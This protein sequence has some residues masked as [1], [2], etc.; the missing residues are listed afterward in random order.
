MVKVLKLPLVQVN[1]LP[2]QLLSL[3]IYL[4]MTRKY[5]N[6]YI[7]LIMLL[8]IGCN[9]KTEYCFD[10]QSE[11]Y[12]LRLKFEGKL[13]NKYN[14]KKNRGFTTLVIKTKNGVIK[15][16]Q[17][18]TNDY[19]LYKDVEQGDSLFKIKGSL[20]IKVKNNKGVK[21]YKDHCVNFRFRLVGDSL[22]KI[23]D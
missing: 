11:K 8:V 10:I 18:L 1:Q 6:Y 20:D 19:Q 12:L 16:Y 21:V 2:L 15:Y 3:L 9:N 13:L 22:I 4:M 17:V 7:I 23:N 14:D 5:Y